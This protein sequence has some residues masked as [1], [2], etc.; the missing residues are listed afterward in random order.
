MPR[1]APASA[2]STRSRPPTV[3][4]CSRWTSPRVSRVSP[5]GHRVHPARA[6]ATVSFA[7]LKPG[8]VLG[9]GPTSR[10]F[11][12]GRRHRARGRRRGRCAPGGALRRRGLGSGS[13]GRRPQ[14]APCGVVR[15]RLSGD[16]GCCVAVR[17]RCAARWSRLRASLHARRPR[18]PCADRGGRARG[19]PG[20]VGGDG[21][22]RSGPLRRGRGRA[23]PG[24][25]RGDAVPR[26][27]I[28]SRS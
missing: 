14:V 17:L 10:R 19:G 16:V 22:G 7:A 27:G 26:C 2:A 20:R 18:P 9:D 3:R 15:R 12:P 5:V 8:L 6:V 11:D 13:P 25:L 1:S 28:W 23:R 24:P 4:R 21:P